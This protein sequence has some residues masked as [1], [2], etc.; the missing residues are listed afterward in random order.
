MLDSVLSP[1]L[2]TVALKRRR[3]GHCQYMGTIALNEWELIPSIRWAV[4][5]FESRKA[6]SSDASTS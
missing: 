4:E 3:T 6:L 1:F 5:A 2:I